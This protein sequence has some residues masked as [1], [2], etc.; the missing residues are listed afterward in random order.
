MLVAEVTFNIGTCY[1]IKKT[2]FE[3]LLIEHLSPINSWNISEKLANLRKQNQH[4]KE[5]NILKH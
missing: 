4:P 5:I 2:L 1:A 3:T